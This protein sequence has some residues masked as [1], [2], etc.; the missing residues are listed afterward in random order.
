MNE[1][2][3]ILTKWSPSNVASGAIPDPE[4]PVGPETLNTY[5]AVLFNIYQYQY[6]HG[7]INDTWKH[8]FDGK[9]RD[10]VKM[11]KER[12][13]RIRR[14]SYKEKLNGEFAPFTTFQHFKQCEEWLWNRG[15]KTR[16]SAMKALR[17][18]FAFVNCYKELLQHE[19]LFLGELSV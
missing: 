6:A 7:I 15:H 16:R 14:A 13:H 4:N 1:F 10:L 8:I 9:C 19:S 2:R 18:R 5:K 11:V 12:T 17:N 3:A